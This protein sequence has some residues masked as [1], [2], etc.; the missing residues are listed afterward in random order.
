[1]QANEVRT[2]VDSSRWTPIEVNGAQSES[3]GMKKHEMKIMKYNTSQWQ[4]LELQGILWEVRWAS[5]IINA[6]HWERLLINTTHAMT[7]HVKQ[8]KHERP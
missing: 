7:I 4:L 6:D 3:I 5:M 8:S 2:K 1:M